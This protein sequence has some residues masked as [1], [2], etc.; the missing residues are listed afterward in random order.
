MTFVSRVPGLGAL[1]VSL[2]LAA[3]G[4]EAPTPP[5]A[6]STQA[7]APLKEAKRRFVP[8]RVIVK[9]RDSAEASLRTSSPT[10]PGFRAQDVKALSGG[11]RLWSLE[12]EQKRVGASIAEEEADLLAA[13]EA[14]RK[15]PRV[16]YAHEDLYMEY[17]AVPSD[18]LYSQQWHYPLI[19]LPTAWSSVTGSVK[20]AVLD[21]GRLDHPDLSGKWTAGQDF[22]DNDAD[23]TDDDTYHHGLHVAGILAARANNG[24]GGAGVCWGCQLM[25]VKVS[26]NNAPVMSNVGNAI[27]WAADNGARVINMSFGTGSATAPC[28]GYAYMQSAVDY[29]VQRNVVVV[30]AAGNDA[31]DTANV[32]PASCNGVIAVAAVGRDGQLATYSNRGGRVDV[33]A[34][35][36]GSPFYGDGINCPVDGTTYSGTDGAVSTWAAYKAG[37]TLQ[38]S[39]YCYRYLSGTSMASPHVAGLAALI[40]SQRPSMTPAQV[41]ARLKSTATPLLCK[42]C[43]SG[44][45]N[46]GAAI[47]PPLPTKP[48]KGN[49]YN[50][51][52]SGNGLDIQSIAV[53][54]LALTWFTY[55]S[56]GEPIWYS[57][58]LTAETG[59]WAG[60][61]YESTW[62]GVSASATK[63]GTAKLTLSSGQ[64]RFAWTKGTL[65]GSEPVQP[66]VFGSGTTVM[67][68]SGNW[69]N[70]QEAGWGILFDSRGTVHVANV[71]IYKGSRAT[72][73]QGVVDSASTSLSFPLSY[74]TGINLCPGCTGTPSTS[75][76]SAGTL[77]VSS[78]AGVPTTASASMQASFPGGTWNRSAFTLSRL[79]GP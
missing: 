74:V 77:N 10:V 63:V 27:R 17:F 65:S 79:T 31:M 24:I 78:H 59:V 58:N 45:I 46:A 35:G 57:S 12:P 56:A 16:E 61:L 47:Y 76:Q 55:T 33:A 32:T 60:D 72:W 15:D 9:F 36:G 62:N 5:E 44:L 28:S 54:A 18:P 71:A 3:C 21:T 2:F 7:P 70:A 30:A 25:P 38:S 1:A 43:G 34:P 26:N 11:A 29:A 48:A 39:D 52:R 42:S 66:L 69:F 14:L 8:G 23:P 51:A 6:P 64:W 68:L 40:L 41:I 37:T 4:G 13:I 75:A 22:G 67:N 20:I 73:L 49:W 50:P 53:D 19:N